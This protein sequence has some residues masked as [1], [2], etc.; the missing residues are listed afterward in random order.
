ME[1][2]TQEAE[3][4]S[5]ASSVSDRVSGIMKTLGTRTRERDLALQ[6]AAEAQAELHAIRAQ[7]EQSQNPPALDYNRPLRQPA[8]QPTAADALNTVSWADLGVA[9]H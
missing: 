1:P 4:D 6:E 2:N 3:A 7:L 9:D 8:A 5:L